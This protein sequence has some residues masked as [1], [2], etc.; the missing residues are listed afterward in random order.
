MRPNSDARTPFRAFAITRRTP[1]RSRSA[2]TT[3]SRR[4]SIACAQGEREPP[5]PG[6][7]P[8]LRQLVGQLDA[9]A[10]PS[11]CPSRSG[12]FA[13]SSAPG[14]TL[15][16]ATSLVAR[17]RA[18]HAA[19]PSASSRRRRCS[20]EGPVA[21]HVEPGADG[22]EDAARHAPR[23]PAATTTSARIGRLRREARASSPSATS[24]TTSAPW[25]APPAGSRSS[26]RRSSRRRRSAGARAKTVAEIW[27]NLRVL[28][29]GG[30]SAAPVFAGPPRAHG[31]RRR[32]PGR[33]V[34]RD[35]GRHLRHDRLQR[36]RD[37]MLM[38]PHRG[39]FFEFVCH[40][41]ARLPRPARAYPSGRSSADRAYSIVVTTVSGLYAYELGDIVRFT[42][43]APL[44]I[45]FMGRLSGCLSVT[46]ELTT[47][48]EIERAVARYAIAQRRLHARSI[49]APRADVGVDGHGASPATSSSSSSAEGAA[50]QDLARVR[51]RLRRRLC[52][53]N[54]VYREHRTDDVAHPRRRASCRSPRRRARAF[55]TRSRAATC[56]ENSRASSTIEE[57]TL[58]WKHA[59]VG[60]RFAT[61]RYEGKST[62][63]R[64]GV[65]IVGVNGA[66]A[67]TRHR[68]RGADE[69]RARAAHRDGH[70]AR[71]RADRRIDHRAARLR[72]A[73]EHRLRRVGLCG[74]RTSTKG[75]STTRCC[76]RTCSSQV[77]RRARA[78]HAL[79]GAS[80]RSDY[81]ENV[82]G[83]NVVNAETHREQIAH[84]Q[85]QHRGLQAREAAST[86]S[87][88]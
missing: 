10:S 77:Q 20:A 3:R 13:T 80:S 48:V 4:S 7:R 44:R 28:F 57:R 79:A 55:S 22:D 27:P 34:Q 38:L 67:S 40:G 15:S 60:S 70:R 65:A 47:H 42:S 62:M 54:R 88:W 21:H 56:R 35:R 69:A 82:A 52:A 33:H 78:H 1:A 72:A 37:G 26:S 66:V 39:T 23:L 6:V 84:P 5:G 83:D 58:L 68:G 17:R 16:C 36:A 87:S 41:R 45:E 11:S 50:P 8:L 59:Q 49:S 71:R 74:S 25:R 81:G 9:R 31:P 53:E 64:I 43:M 86:A 29:G 14:L 61:H 19:S 63:N 12:R 46:Q 24:T 85:A 76:R 73:R 75:R 51:R 2:T 30:V 32:H 18:P